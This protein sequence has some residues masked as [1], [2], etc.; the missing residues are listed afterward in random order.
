MKR[1]VI[2]IGILLALVIAP[3]GAMA[4]SG[5]TSFN[6]T[7]HPTVNVKAN[8]PGVNVSQ[9]HP[10]QYIRVSDGTNMTVNIT[11]IAANGVAGTVQATG[12]SPTTLYVRRTIYNH[13]ISNAHLYY[14]GRVH[15]THIENHTN[16]SW[17]VFQAN[18][19]HKT[20]FAIRS[21][22]LPKHI[23]PNKSVHAK[24]PFN[25]T[26]GVPSGP[27]NVSNKS[28][29]HADVRAGRA[30]VNVTQTQN[31]V[32]KPVRFRVDSS[33][34]NGTTVYIKYSVLNKS[35]Q[36]KPANVAAYFD[37][38]STAYTTQRV[39]G[40]LWVAVNIPHFSAHNLEFQNVGYA[41][42]AGNPGTITV[43]GF[44]VPRTYLI[45][46]AIVVLLLVIG[47]Y[48]YYRDSHPVS[49]INP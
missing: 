49:H 1:R 9:Y 39:N 7:H 45:G 30:N 24:V 32:G 12:N 37:G 36:T 6:N 4:T 21:T 44:S 2:V 48:L 41:T 40:T 23:G 20:D 31:T 11:A 29:G 10:S 42:T 18:V 3:M 46:A 17:Y 8:I 47:G 28:S 35:L 25:K 19:S 22:N 13:T 33:T 34:H 38:N 43:Y 15:S 27:V 16:E 26:V 14:N 5:E